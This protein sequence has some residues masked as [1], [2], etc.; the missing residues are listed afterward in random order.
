MVHYVKEPINMTHTLTQYQA[1]M[2]L[3]CLMMLGYKV[4]LVYCMS[5][6]LLCS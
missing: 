4:I 2:S 3:V 6:K 5:Y 1:Q